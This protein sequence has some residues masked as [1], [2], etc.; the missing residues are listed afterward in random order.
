MN[1]TMR[2]VKRKTKHR[3][4]PRDVVVGPD[5]CGARITDNDDDDANRARRRARV[6]ACVPRLFRLIFKPE[7]YTHHNHAINTT[8]AHTHTHTRAGHNQ[9]AQVRHTQPHVPERTIKAIAWADNYYCVRMHV[10]VHFGP[11]RHNYHLS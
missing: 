4:T 2:L 7:K 11:V 8:H 10:H 1:Y 5:R 9:T 6:R 3:R